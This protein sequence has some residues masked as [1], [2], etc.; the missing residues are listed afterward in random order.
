MRIALGILAL[1]GALVVV[2]WALLFF[3]QRAL[4]FPA[5]SL[6]DAP[7]RPADAEVVHLDTPDGAVE[8]WDLP[9]LAQDSGPAPLLIFAHGN[10]ELIDYWPGEFTTPRRWGIAVLLVEYPGYGR[11]AGR[12]AQGSITAAMLAAHA[13]AAQRPGIDARR[14]VA[15]GRSLGG[16]AAS[17]L[18]AARPV[19]ALVLESS[20]T[21]VGAFA[22]RFGAPAFLVRDRFDNRAVVRSLQAPVLIL[23]GEYD[24]IIPVSHAHALHAAQPASELV[25]VPWAHNDMPRLW[26][27]VERFLRRHAILAP[28][29]Q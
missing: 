16:G 11:S 13:W 5:P 14:I 17:A 25:V 22:R 6:A 21:S 4:L 12:P 10:G 28:A 29:T 9:P 15:Y 3:G 2:Y 27:V 26:S 24:D 8:A 18:A 20:F 7:T 1:V 23:H 19:A